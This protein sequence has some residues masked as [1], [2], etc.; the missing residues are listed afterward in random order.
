MS[1]Q[2]S[3]DSTAFDT[4]YDPQIDRDPFCLHARPAIGAPAVALVSVAHN[5][6]QLVRVLVEVVAVSSNI[7]RSSSDCD[8]TVDAVDGR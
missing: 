3:M 1:P 4:Q 6:K 2:G 7:A 8:S 5:L